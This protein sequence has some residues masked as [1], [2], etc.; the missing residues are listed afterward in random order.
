M[1][2]AVLKQIKLSLYDSKKS[3][4]AN[5]VTCD[6]KFCTDTYNG[7]LPGC[8]PELLC[9]YNVVYG[10]GSSTSGY[11]VHDNVQFNAVTGDLQTSSANGSVIFGCVVLL[12]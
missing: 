4:T 2:I 6:E 7:P 9:Q 12:L 5:L 11:F 3:S 1:L 8:R 10:D